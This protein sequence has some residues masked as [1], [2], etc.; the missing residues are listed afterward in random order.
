MQFV[1]YL[2]REHQ[3]YTKEDAAMQHFYDL[4]I[5]LWLEVAILSQAALL[6][7]GYDNDL[8]IQCRM[9][10]LVALILR[11]TSLKKISSSHFGFL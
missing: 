3:I 8:Q 6:L 9:I 7:R 10:E 1:N 11:Q 4:Q 2:M 5:F